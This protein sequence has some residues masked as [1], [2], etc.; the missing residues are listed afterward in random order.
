M[1][2]DCLVKKFIKDYD[3]TTDSVVRKKYGVLSSWVG[4]ACNILLFF[5]KFIMGTLANSIAIISDGFNNL[6]DCISCIITMFGYKL[7]SKPADKDHPFGHGRMEYLTSF[8]LSMIIIMVG[9][10]LVK[11]SIDKL[12]H[13]EEVVFSGVAVA[14]L[15]ISICV[16]L[17]MGFF[18]G[19]LAKKINSGIMRATSKDSFNDVIATSVT[20]LSL[21]ISNYSDLPADGVLGVLVSLLIIKSGIEI[22]RETVDELLGQPADEELVEQIKELVR[23][24]WVALDMHD[25][26]IHSYGPGNLLG[27]IHVEVD[28]RGDIMEIHD[29]I[30]ELER[31]IY[32]ELGVVTTIHMD[33]VDTCDEKIKSCRS[34]LNEIIVG[35]DEKLSIHDFRIVSGPTHTNLIFDMVVPYDAAYPADEA[36]K[37]INA[38][39]QDKDEKYYAVITIDRAYT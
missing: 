13:P 8:L 22:V 14:V 10:E 32:D 34:M 21:I 18:N 27:S 20:L 23:E 4:I 24:S 37:K 1:L 15:V 6:S 16:K 29:A 35:I 25:L 3:N 7:A 33:P 36:V 9:F 31:N 26:I 17:W 12:L 39:L 38:A 11:T 2:T 28:S 30:D 5:A 19:R